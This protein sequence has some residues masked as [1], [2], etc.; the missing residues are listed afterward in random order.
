MHKGS[1]MTWAHGGTQGCLWEQGPDLGLFCGSESPSWPC[2][3]LRDGVL[4]FSHQAWW[5]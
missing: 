5:G 1:Q 4:A 2:L 3:G